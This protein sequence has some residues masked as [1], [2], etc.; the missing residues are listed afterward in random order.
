MGEGRGH[1]GAEDE[2]RPDGEGDQQD[3]KAD[4]WPDAGYAQPGREEGAAVVGTR[5]DREEAGDHE[6]CSCH[7]RSL[8]FD[9]VEVVFILETLSVYLLFTLTP[10][11]LHPAAFR[12]LP[13]QAAR[14]PATPLMLAAL[15]A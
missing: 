10:R 8:L 1:L 13:A 5:Y 11:D 14:L 4:D 15:T 3:G 9:L 2:E 12:N 7:R 6:Q